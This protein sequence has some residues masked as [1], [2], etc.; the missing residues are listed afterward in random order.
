[1]NSFDSFLNPE[2]KPNIRFKLSSYPDEFEMRLLSAEEDREILR[3]MRED[4]KVDSADALI[5]YAAEALVIP[6]LRNAD[7][8]NKLSKIA[9]HPIMSPADALVAMTTSAELAAILN[10][11]AEFS[12]VDVTFTE[13]VEEIKN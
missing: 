10:T 5:A 11:Y 4:K 7:F 6:D 8:Q 13:G 1:M 9:G 12:G 2:R 3:R